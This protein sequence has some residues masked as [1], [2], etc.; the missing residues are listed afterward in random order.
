MGDWHLTAAARE[1]NAAA[2]EDGFRIA[3]EGG[4]H[5]TDRRGA[6]VCLYLTSWENPR[7]EKRIEHLEFKSAG[8]RP[9]PFLIAVTAG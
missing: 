8:E 7:P 9:A 1:A 6:R 5:S 2:G 3:W 4:N